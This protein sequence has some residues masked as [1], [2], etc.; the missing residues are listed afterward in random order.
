MRNGYFFHFVLV[1]KDFQV[2][3]DSLLAKQL[4]D[5][6]CMLFFIIFNDELDKW[7]HV[8]ALY[9]ESPL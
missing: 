6:E 2:K 8:N 9:Q 1:R 7:N 5:R 3:E 4:Q